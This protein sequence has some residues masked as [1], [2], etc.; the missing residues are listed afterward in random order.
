MLDG[1]KYLILVPQ[2]KTCI[3]DCIL[4]LDILCSGNSIITKL[5]NIYS[6]TISKLICQTMI[7]PIFIFLGKSS[8]KVYTVTLN[9][10]I[11]ETVSIFGYN[12]VNIHIQKIRQFCFFSDS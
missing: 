2:F 6:V 7:Y 3:T 4:Q 9:H 10:I 5:V 1:E 11:D 12:K 8:L